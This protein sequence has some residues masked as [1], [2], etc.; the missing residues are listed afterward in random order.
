VTVIGAVD[1]GESSIVYDATSG[2]FSILPDGHSVGLFDIQSASGI[3]TA[4]AMFPPAGLGF[5]VDTATRKSW[6]AL[7]AAAFSGNFSLGLIAAPGLTKSFLLNDLT[8]TGSG[9][10]STPNRAL[11]LVYRTDGD[12]GFIVVVDAHLETYPGAQV[13]HQFIAAAGAPPITW[14]N[15]TPLLG[16]PIPNIAPMLS[17]TGQFNWNTAG[18][19]YGVY[20][21]E[22]TASNAAGSDT[23]RLAVALL[24]E[25]EPATITLAG[26]AIIALG[27]LRRRREIGHNKWQ[28]FGVFNV[29]EVV[30]PQALH[31]VAQ[32]RAAHPGYRVHQEAVTPKALN[33]SYRRDECNAF[34][35][36]RIFF[37]C[38]QGAPLRGDPGLWN[39][40][41][42]R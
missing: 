10:F 35:V 41:A 29:L 32:G 2:V 11:D 22:V 21:W 27:A 9:G 3:F 33:N 6:A 7:P 26:M 34:G 38:R 36:K 24:L 28:T 25:P 20:A 17:A 8:L 12:E 42:S 30:T 1:D 40:T 4:S 31:S 15:L 23:G 18:S 16:N 14:S 39:L 5:E 37:L 19:P 13:S